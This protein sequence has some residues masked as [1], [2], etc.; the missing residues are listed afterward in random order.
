MLRKIFF[1]C[2]EYIK[3][4]SRLSIVQMFDMDNKHAHG[5]C[6]KVL[7][8]KYYDNSDAITTEM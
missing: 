6:L 4:H 8:T 2:H 5:K 1:T 7:K 3:V